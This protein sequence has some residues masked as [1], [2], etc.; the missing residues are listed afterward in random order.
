V[1]NVA[2]LVRGLE[3]PLTAVQL[4]GDE[5]IENRII[6]GAPTGIVRG[7]Q[8]PIAFFAAHVLVASLLETAAG[9]RVFIFRT[10]FEGSRGSY[11][12]GVFPSV[13]LLAEARTK[14]A[15]ALI[16]NLLLWVPKHGHDIDRLSDAFWLRVSNVV[17]DRRRRG[18]LA[19]PALL[20]HERS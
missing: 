16:R 15:A 13:Q 3:S 10:L 4:L 7:R 8:G 2:P 5:D 6:H 17:A 20:A 9:T 11:V 19:L 1:E 18:R 12:P 14:G